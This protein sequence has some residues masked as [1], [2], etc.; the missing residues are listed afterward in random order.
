MPV[1]VKTASL[2]SQIGPLATTDGGSTGDPLIIISWVTNVS[3]PQSSV[4]LYVRVMVSGQLFPSEISLTNATTGFAEQLSAASVTT[5]MS[6]I[7]AGATGMLMSEGFD[8]VGG[9]FS[10]M[11]YV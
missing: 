5:D 1:I 9:I 10:L 11:V 2:P 7:G 6:G 8:A 3:L 4:M